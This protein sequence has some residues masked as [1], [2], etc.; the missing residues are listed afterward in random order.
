[1]PFKPL[2]YNE[3]SH[4]TPSNY[5]IAKRGYVRA[6]RNL[7]C[8]NVQPLALAL[9]GQYLIGLELTTL[10]NRR[11]NLDL[12]LDTMS[13]RVV[14]LDLGCRTG[15][16]ALS[17]TGFLTLTNARRSGGGSGGSILLHLHGIESFALARLFFGC[18]LLELLLSLRKDALL[19]LDQ[20]HHC[21]EILVSL[22]YQLMQTFVLGFLQ[23]IDVCF[24]VIFLCSQLQCV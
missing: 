17:I 11:L 2:L 20:I 6:I 1:M 9:C 22:R 10:E 7:L 3:T 21:V 15:N 19:R 18:L 23:Q 13:H 12:L 5:T 4:C 8:H 24:L 16:F 14:G